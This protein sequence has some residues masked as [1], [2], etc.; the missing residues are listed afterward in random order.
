MF[1]IQ[2]RDA[3]TLISI[4]LLNVEL[5]SLIVSDGW[6]GCSKLNKNKY[7]HKKVIHEENFID[8]FAGANTQQIECEWG[9]AKQIIEIQ[10]KETILGLLE[11]HLDKFCFRKKIYINTFLKW[12]LS[13]ITL[14]K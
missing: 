14:L 7:I 10:R 13:T 1:Y 8:F 12:L 6:K 2:K 11:F 9:R 3:N 4:I 5:I